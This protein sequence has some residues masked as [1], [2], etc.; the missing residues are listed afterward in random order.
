MDVNFT[1]S[2]GDSSGMGATPT[3]TTTLKTTGTSCTANSECL[4]G[5]CSTSSTL[6]GIT[7]P[8]GSTMRPNC[9]N[10]VW[11][12]VPN[13]PFVCTYSLGCKIYCG[14]GNKWFDLPYNAAS[15]SCTSEYSD[16]SIYYN[17][18]INSCT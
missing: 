16:C 13:V 17:I 10:L 9:V 2:A 14:G 3:N 4:S 6:G 5:V 11:Q 1:S 18:A 7:N 15:N 8:D 12:T